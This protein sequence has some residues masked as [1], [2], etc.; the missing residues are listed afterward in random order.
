MEAERCEPSARVKHSEQAQSHVR[1]MVGSLNSQLDGW[2]ESFYD[3]EPESSQLVT[4]MM[5]TAIHSAT[6]EARLFQLQQV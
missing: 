5:Q 6:P 3:G 2:K 4:L 1:R